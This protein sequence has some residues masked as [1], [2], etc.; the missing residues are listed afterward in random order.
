MEGDIVLTSNE[1]QPSRFVKFLK[2]WGIAIV[3]VAIVVVIATIFAAQSLKSSILEILVAPTFATVKINGEIY[4]SSGSFAVFPGTYDVEISAEGFE[5]KELTLNLEKDSIQKLY[6]YLNDEDGQL[7]LYAKFPD[8]IS[9]LQLV[10]DNDS[11]EFLDWYSVK[12]IL[13]IYYQTEDTDIDQYKNIFISYETENCKEQP[14]C[15]SIHD[16]FNGNYDFAISLIKEYGYDPSDYEILYS[17]T[18]EKGDVEE[19]YRI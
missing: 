4:P 19:C 2:K 14:F 5:T 10:G 17:Y 8:N 16:A 7:S 12:D 6:T 9:L 15:L 1:K 3:D 13:P 18:C 11:K